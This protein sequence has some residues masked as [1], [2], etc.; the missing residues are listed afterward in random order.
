MNVWMITTIVL[1][2]TLLLFIFYH[3]YY[4]MNIT[5]ITKQLEEIMAATD[6]NQLLSI[7]ARQSDITKLVNKLNHLLRNTRM[8]RI[9]IKRLNKSFRQSITNISHDLRTP[10]TTASGYIQMLEKS[11]TDKEQQEYLEIILERQNMVQMLLDQLFE[12]VRIESGEIIYGHV[13]ID[14]KKIFL[15]TIAMYYNDFNKKKQ[16]PTIH[17]TEGSCIIQGD[18]QGLKRIFSNILFNA[19]I[20]GNGDYCFEIQEG[21]NYIFTFSNISEPMTKEDLDNIFER[22]YTKDGSRNKKTTGLGLAIA[23]EITR[24]LNGKIK[25]VY[26]NKHLSISISFQKLSNPM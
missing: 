7:V 6:T 2:L 18:E 22:F 4:R 19:L 1:S 8:S 23:K 17:L 15:D 20:H 12:Y 13:P 14:A 5:H 24:Q 10:L 16:E 3:M 26:N 25:A 21:D 9:Q 11:I